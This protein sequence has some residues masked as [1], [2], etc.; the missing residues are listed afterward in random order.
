MDLLRVTPYVSSWAFALGRSGSPS[1]QS[2]GRVKSLSEDG[3]ADDDGVDEPPDPRMTAAFRTWL[4]ALAT[5][6]EAATAAAMAYESLA[7]DGRAAWLDAVEIEA[8]DLDVPALAL[9]APLLGV[10]VDE[11]RRARMEAALAAAPKTPPPARTLRAL[12]GQ[13]PGGEM[14][15]AFVIPLYLDFVELLVCRYQ[16]DVGIASARRGPLLRADDVWGDARAVREIDGALLSE[17]PF[18]HVVEDV[19]HAVVADLREGRS[20]PEPL[21]SFDFLF[22]VTLEG[23][24][25]GLFDLSAAFADPGS[26]P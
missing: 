23:K 6:P 9:Y 21:R 26:S 13:N 12:H 11:P 18:A 15:A 4:L 25:D 2:R 24:L 14:V 22:A 3:R 5:D 17:A 16:P 7:P 1:D 8:R 20:P 19:A 10:E